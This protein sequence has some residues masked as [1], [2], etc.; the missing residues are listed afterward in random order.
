MA[1]D[2]H[3][4]RALTPPAGMPFKIQ[5]L[6]HVV[7]QV[8]NLDRS[9]RF[10][11]QVLGSKCRMFTPRMSNR[12]GLPF[13]AATPII[14]PSLLLAVDREIRSM[15]SCITLPSRW[16][17]SPRWSRC[18]KRCANTMLRSRSK[19]VAEPVAKSPWSFSTP[20]SIPLRSIGEWIKLEPTVM[21]VRRANGKGS[22][23]LKRRSP[24]R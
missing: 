17:R 21:C 13:C 10:Y 14:M 24:I 4:W 8:S 9:M 2:I 6:G 12:E 7:L 22:K 18:A 16:R 15:L 23:P 20:T 19:G 1:V 5:R 3:E 11:T